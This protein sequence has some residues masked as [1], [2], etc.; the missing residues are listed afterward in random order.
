MSS[1]SS[2]GRSRA[3]EKYEIGDQAHPFALIR[4]VP[5]GACDDRLERGRP[6]LADLR[7]PEGLLRGARHRPGERRPH[8]VDDA[9]LEHRLRPL[10]NPPLEDIRRDLEAHDH[11][12]AARGPAQSRSWFATSDAPSSARSSA[13]TRRLRSWGWTAAAAAE[14]RSSE[15]EDAR[16]AGRDPPHARPA[17]VSPDGRRGECP[18]R[19]AQPSGRGRCRHRP[20]LRRD[21][22][23]ARRSHRGR[24]RRTLRRSS[25]RRARGSP[26]SRVGAD[27]WLVRIGS[28]R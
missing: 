10:A 11:R 1:A 20:L 15:P 25:P 13:R 3:V 7:E 26:T 28:P 22:R 18:A 9:T 17:R 12:R 16:R 6:Q 8:L 24:A 4:G 23:R 21:R 27:G 19:P 2:P 5:A 14:S